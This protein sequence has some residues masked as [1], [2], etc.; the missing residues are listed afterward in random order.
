MVDEVATY[1]LDDLAQVFLPA[2]GLGL[3]FGTNLYAGL[4]PDHP[5]VAST[6]FE[7]PGAKPEYVMGAANPL[8]AIAHPRVQVVSR[9]PDYQAGRDVIEQIVRTLEAVC[10]QT[11]NGTYYERIERLQ[12]PF[13]M[14]RDTSRRCFFACNVDVARTPS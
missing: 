7:Y 9:N 3:I 5:D 8:P 14:H 11:I 10:N 13:L 1:I 4:M 2:A 12:D 6:L